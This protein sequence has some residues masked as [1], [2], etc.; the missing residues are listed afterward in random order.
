MKAIKKSIGKFVIF[1]LLVIALF[2]CTGGGAVQKEELT[3]TQQSVYFEKNEGLDTAIEEAASYFVQRLA[4]GA[5]VAIV[6]FDAPTGR[7]SDYVFEEM[8]GF[9]EDSGKFVMVDRRNLDRIN[10]EINYQLGSGRVYDDFIVSITRQYGAEVLVYGQVV[11][12]DGE[13]RMTVYATDVESA[14]SSQRAYNVKPDNRLAALLNVTL[15]DEIERALSVMARAVDQ[16]TTI[17][18][19]RISYGNTETVTALSAWLGN[20]IIAGAQRHRDKLQVAS[21]SESVDFAVS[22]R[23]LTV[24]TQS[25]VQAVVIGNYSPLDNG[26]EVSLHLVA[27]SGN[28]AVL[29]SSR[30]AI[31]A[32]EL[33]RRGLSLLPEKGGAVVT[34]AEFEA[35][36]LVVNPYEGRNNRWAFTI[37]PDTLNGIYREGDYMTMRLYS[38]QD[39]YF[40]IV[41]VD[42]NGSTQVIYP[43]TARDSNFIRAGETRR[44]PD[45]TRYR[46]GQP[47]GEEM[48]LAAAYDRPFLINT[49][50][51]SAPISAEIITRSLTAES[52]N[53]ATMS[54]SVTAKFSYTILPRE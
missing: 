41:H 37:T 3:E 25:G 1:N 39:C 15:N 6:P 10:T 51:G 40:R 7:L 35:R 19:G 49:Q 43:T 50:S 47:F 36:Q 21:E 34:Q 2:G 42:V 45:N 14:S 32:S 29:A 30:F 27:T 53:N 8:W 23:G 48:I 11:A 46:M 33:E 12:L 22:S 28:K 18:V 9:I 20:A 38:A 26:A 13:Y 5:K 54:P 44:I 31:P 52:D 16:R 4:N 24:D 17:A